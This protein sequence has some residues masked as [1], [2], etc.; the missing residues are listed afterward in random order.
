MYSFMQIE[1]YEP[2]FVE[3]NHAHTRKKF[4]FV[5]TKEIKYWWKLKLCLTQY[6][7]KARAQ[8]EII[9]LRNWA[10]GHGDLFLPG[11]KIVFY[12][13]VL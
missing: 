7:F 5:Y 9:C 6:L 4:G 11:I 3:I 12:L 8:Q 13:H 10:A 2:Q 1:K